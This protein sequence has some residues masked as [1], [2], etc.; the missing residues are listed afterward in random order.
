[1]L[2]DHEAAFSWVETE[3]ELLPPGCKKK[4]EVQALQAYSCDHDV[5]I[6]KIHSWDMIAL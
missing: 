4:K 6:R 5:K 2:A 3:H 1:M